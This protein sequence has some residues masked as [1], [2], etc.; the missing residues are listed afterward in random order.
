MPSHGIGK[1]KPD[2]GSLRCATTDAQEEVPCP[3]LRAR[4]CTGSLQRL[5]PIL[6]SI[7]GDGVRETLAILGDHMDGLTVSEIP[8]GETCFDW[9]IPN[10]WNLREA[11]IE[12]GTGRRIIDFKENNLHVL[13]YSAPVDGVFSLE[14]LTPHI[15][16]LPNQPDAIPYRTSYYVR[17]LGLLHGPFSICRAETRQLPGQN[18][19]H[20]GSRQPDLC[21]QAHCRP[22]GTRGS[23][24]DL[25]LSPVDGEQ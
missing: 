11:F 8:T 19:F 18:R 3:D 7:T 9:T 25:R 5:F 12:D 1:G 20:A 10:E 16:T 14:E 22:R 4:K 23:A 24:F 13:N 2:A 21:R 17:T 15:Y 6:R